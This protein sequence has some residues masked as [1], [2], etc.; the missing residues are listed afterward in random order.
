M[1][2]TAVTVGRLRDGHFRVEDGDAEGGLA[3]AAGHFQVRLL[4]GDQGERLG[5]AA[6]AGRGRHA[7]GRQ[8]RLGRLAEA[9]VVGHLAAVGQQEVDALGAVHRAAAADGDDEVDAVRAGERPAPAST[10]RVVGF[11]S[12]PSK[13]NDL[14]AGLAQRRQGALRMAGR[15]QAGVG[16]EQ[17]APA[18]Q[19]A[20]QLAQAGERAGPEDDARQRVVVERR[21]A[22][23]RGCRLARRGDGG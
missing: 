8:H 20:R 1:P 3:V 9:L 12:T 4:V 13:T 16:D 14:Q 22:P 2:V 15:L 10:C 21:Q 18:A 7:D 19:L 11:S 5:L 6:G 23:R 17:D